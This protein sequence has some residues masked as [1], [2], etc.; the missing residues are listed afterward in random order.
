M[1]S[2]WANAGWL[3]KGPFVRTTNRGWLGLALLLAAP[4][5]AGEIRMPR[6]EAHGAAQAALAQGDADAAAHIA[7]VIATQYP[8]D[9]RARALL[10]AAY[11]QLNQPAA[12]RAQARLSFGHAGA[13]RGLRHETARLAALAAFRQDRPLVAKYWLRRA[14][15]YAPTP[16]AAHQIAQDFRQVDATDRWQRS[17]AFSLVPSSNINGGSQSDLLEIDGLPWVGTLSPDAQ[18]LAGLRATLNARLGTRL[19]QTPTRQTDIHAH[20]FAS[21]HRLSH[22]ARMLAP[23]LSG[24]DFDQMQFGIEASHRF[25]PASAKGPYDLRAG[26]S[27][28]WLGGQRYLH[29]LTMGAGKITP[30]GAQMLLDTRLRYDRELA[31]SPRAANAHRVALHA[32]LSRP[33]GDGHVITGARLGQFTSDNR[34]NSHDTFGAL[35]RYSPGAWPGGIRASFGLAY[36]YRHFPD[37]IAGMF[38]VPGG[39][40]DHGLGAQAEFTL[41]A[42]Q[43]MGF[44]PV[45]TIGASRNASNVS[46]YQTRDIN[47]GLSFRSAF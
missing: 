3:A 32:S 24:R 34:S 1:P 13:D 5:Q 46:R 41:A 12:A 6:A 39:R 10:A 31:D 45:M 38:P 28:R 30:V 35:I 20:L 19:V 40:K 27:Q 16:Q 15:D 7:A 36:E 14:S 8:E 42:T 47:L 23:G 11:L 18:A 25:A 17:V 21:H 26:L 43:F 2:F 33:L 9:A 37:H 29:S 44:A 4:V 22:E